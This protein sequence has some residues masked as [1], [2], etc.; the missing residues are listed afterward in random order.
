M[1]RWRRG[2]ATACLTAGLI[3]LL[4]PLAAALATRG[5][6]IDYKAGV[7]AVGLCFVAAI[8]VSGLTVILL[9]LQSMKCYRTRLVPA[10]VLMLPTT[11]LGVQALYTIRSVP[12]IHDVTT[13]LVDPPQFRD[14]VKHR[15]TGQNSL[16]VDPSVLAIQ[17]TAYPELGSLR[18]NTVY[19][20]V[21]VAAQRLATE[22]GWQVYRADLDAGEIEAMAQTFWFGF[23]DDIAIRLRRDGKTTVVDVRSASRVGIGD[24]GA[25]ASRIKNFLSGLALALQE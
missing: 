8:L 6:L 13:D 1:S 23:K 21:F 24:L 20:E 18:L 19:S 10:L 2:S 5:G 9:C 16:A 15:Q 7:L 3:L 4:G 17:E 14:T 22:K 11:L 12:A 25:N